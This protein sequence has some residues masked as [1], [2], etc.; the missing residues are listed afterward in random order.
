MAG[1]SAPARSDD[2]RTTRAAAMRQERR[3]AVLDAS[4]P[5]GLIEGSGSVAYARTMA[6]TTL[7]MFQLFNVFNSRSDERSAFDGLFSNGWLWVAAG[8]SL[9]LQV[10]VVYTPF[11]QEAFSTSSLSVGDWFVCGVVASSVLWMRELSKMLSRSS[12]FGARAV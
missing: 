7:V 10:V 11:L 12:V 6:F 3:R 1:V 2:G 4:L 5:G 8:F 9:L